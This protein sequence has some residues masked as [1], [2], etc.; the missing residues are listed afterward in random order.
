MTACATHH[1]GLR[2]AALAVS[3][4]FLIILVGTASARPSTLIQGTPS[5]STSS[6]FND[7]HELEAFPSVRKNPPNPDDGDWE[8][9][10]DDLNEC[11]SA[12]N[13]AWANTAYVK[14]S[15][16]RKKL[17]S[18]IPSSGPVAVKPDPNE[19]LLLA[20]DMFRPTV[21]AYHTIE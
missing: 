3:S 21:E 17:S 11:Q 7:V 20:E 18:G 5:F 9:L 1:F 8:N 13:G 10:C 6:R 12:T 15:N 14:L 19:Q 4:F 2:H 16:W